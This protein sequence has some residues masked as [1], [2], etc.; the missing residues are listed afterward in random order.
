MLP[1]GVAVTETLAT[2]WPAASTLVAELM[3]EL[4]DITAVGADESGTLLLAVA[5]PS[6]ASPLGNE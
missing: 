6:D 2:D 1:V 3:S 5:T 4:D